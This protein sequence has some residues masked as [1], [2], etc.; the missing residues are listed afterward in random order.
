MV[1]LE[2]N[3][4]A[5]FFPVR[6]FSCFS[7]NEYVKIASTIPNKADQNEILRKK[8]DSEKIKK[9]NMAMA[10]TTNISVQFPQPSAEFEE[11]NPFQRREKKN[12]GRGSILSV[13][14]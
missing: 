8:A 7:A 12:S 13:I 5:S 4:I 9:T 11:I 6:N 14:C 1:T 2:A 3:T 10:Y